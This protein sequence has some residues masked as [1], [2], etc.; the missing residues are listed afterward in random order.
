MKK[1]ILTSTGLTNP[2]IKEELLNLLNVDINNVKCLFIPT[3]AVTN[4]EKDLLNIS[5]QTLIDSG[6]QPGN[7]IMYNCDRYIG[8]DEL[9]TYKIIYIGGGDSKYLLNALKNINVV[10]ELSKAINSN[11]IIYIGESAGS[12]IAKDLDIT[13]VEIIPH[14]KKNFTSNGK[15]F[16]KNGVVSLNNNQALVITGRSMNVIS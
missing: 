16:D 14:V 15:F 13:N 8:Y 11:E 3:G 6:L 1:L 10:E 5:Y 12:I 4:E 2:R 9:I 7:I